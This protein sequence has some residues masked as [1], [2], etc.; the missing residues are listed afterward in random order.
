MFK[1]I[2][3]QTRSSK[4]FTFD[5]RKIAFEPGDS[6][7]AA[8]LAASVTAFRTHPITKTPRGPYCMMGSCF[9]CLAEIDGSQNQQTCMTPARERMQVRTQSGAKTIG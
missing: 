4:A 1:R 2:N 5:G 7:A 9:E 8:L 6:V 3:P